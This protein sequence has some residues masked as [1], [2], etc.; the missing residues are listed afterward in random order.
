MSK[1]GLTEAFGGVKNSAHGSAS[2]H[3]SGGRLLP[4]PEPGLGAAWDFSG[5]PR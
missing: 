1:T 4:R 2:A 3:W 5:Q